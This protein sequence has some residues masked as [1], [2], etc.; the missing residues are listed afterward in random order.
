MDSIDK[1]LRGHE[2]FRHRY[3]N[4]DPALFERLARR[5]QA[6]EVAVVA[7]C[8]SRV[9]PAIVTDCD[10]GD[11]FTIR[12]VANLVPP[13]EPE[14]VYHGTSAALEFAVRGLAVKH[15][16]VLGHAQCGGVQALMSGDYAQND[17]FIGDWMNIAREARERVLADPRFADAADRQRGCEHASIGISLRNLMTFPWIRDLVERGQLHLHGWY[18]DLYNGALLQRDAA[19]GEFR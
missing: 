11:L 15:V 10:P 8:D 12:N 9:D 7:C 13:H 1:L 3:F 18:F 4:D 19:T 6:P 14:G 2:R 16:V 5:G 17:D